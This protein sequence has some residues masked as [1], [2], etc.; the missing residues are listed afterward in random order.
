MLVEKH[1]IVLIYPFIHDLDRSNPRNK[2]RWKER[3]E[4]L[5][6]RWRP[7]WT[8]KLERA[9]LSETIDDSYFFFPHLRKLLFPEVSDGHP[10]DQEN[11]VHQRIGGKFE[12]WAWDLGHH[13]VQR[14]TLKLDGDGAA[15]E[16]NRYKIRSD[17]DGMEAHLKINWVDCLLF[18]QGVGFLLIAVEWQEGPSGGRN[19][20]T[21]EVNDLLY[22][23]KTIQ[24]PTMRFQLPRW[25]AGDDDQTT[26]TSRSL[27][28]FLVQGMVQQQ[29]ATTETF[30]SFVRSREDAS[31]PQDYTM[32]P[33]GQVFGEQFRRLVYVCLNGSWDETNRKR[34]ENLF[35][36]A[37]DWQAYE[38][39][40]ITQI[41]DPEF[42]PRAESLGDFLRSRVYRF[43]DNWSGLSAHDSV[44]FVG[45]S[46]TKF[47]LD[48]LPR[49]VE[50]DYLMLYLLTLYQYV[51]LSLLSG[52]ILSYDSNLREKREKAG[53]YWEQFIDFRNHYWF[54]EPTPK[55][56]GGDLYTLFQASMNVPRIFEGL[57]EEL[58]ELQE[59]FE[60][61]NERNLERGIRI[62]TILSVVIGA[63]SL[64][65]GWFGIDLATV[66]YFLCSSCGICPPTTGN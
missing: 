37:G 15:L 11:Q 58:S 2:A 19:P 39:A 46:A 33:N 25:T 18:P 14:M 45:E 50:A 60:Q 43:W 6:K 16:G 13:A 63:L 26:F 53:Q 29:V 51:R 47:N 8:R 12:D 41:K 24:P 61:R 56:Q 28:E 42:R 59:Y 32:T 66:N 48:R 35:D 34:A 64:A 21:P 22:L 36:T 5:G 1:S 20:D 30:K 65:V 10:K 23:L 31:H 54:A 4:A 40:T 44:V 55:P 49:Q 17:Y 52:E 27:V 7:W 38:L 9:S 57:R 62:L 3:M